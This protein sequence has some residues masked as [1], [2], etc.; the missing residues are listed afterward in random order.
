MDKSVQIDE[1][2]KDFNSKLKKIDKDLENKKIRFK[3]PRIN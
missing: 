3:T 2:L 1:A